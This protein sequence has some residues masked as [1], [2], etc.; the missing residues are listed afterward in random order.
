MRRIVLTTEHTQFYA[1]FRDRC[2]HFEHPHPSMDYF[3]L[4]I[5]LNT[6]RRYVLHESNYRQLLDYKPN[7]AILPWGAT[8]AHNYHLPHGTD[9]IQAATLATESAR[10][11][12]ASGAKPIVL[13]VGTWPVRA[14]QESCP[15]D[16]NEPTHAAALE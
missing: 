9:V 15:S 4:E 14:R 10:L 12:H 3:S 5:V 16:Q 1:S 13:P 11:A 7:V 2:S 6:P 8:E